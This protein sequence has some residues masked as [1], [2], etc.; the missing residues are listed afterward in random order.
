MN[1]CIINRPNTKKSPKTPHLHNLALQQSDGSEKL[2]VVKK[3]SKKSFFNVQ[4]DLW[5]GQMAHV[6]RITQKNAM[7]IH[8]AVK[9]VKPSLLFSFS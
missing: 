2:C 7:Q 4:N 9:P 6:G 3:T 8:P 5:Q 1:E